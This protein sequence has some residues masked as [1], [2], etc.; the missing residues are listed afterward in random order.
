MQGKTLFNNVVMSKAEAVALVANLVIDELMER[1]T[2]H[3]KVRNYF[4]IAVL[5][6]GNGGIRSLLPEIL[7]D[8]FASIEY[9]AKFQPE[10][11]R[12]F[13]D[14]RRND[15][16]MISVPFSYHPW[17]TPRAGG[18]TPMYE[19]LLNVRELV[20]EWCSQPENRDSFPPIVFNI[21]DGEC[22]DA[23]P[24]ELITIARHITDISTNDGNILLINVHLAS[25]YS[26]DKR[27]V[28]ACDNDFHTNNR[29]CQTL[30]EMSSL[31]P[32]CMEGSISQ[33]INPGT[34]GPYRGLAINASVCDM[35]MVLNMGSESLS[36]M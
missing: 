17:I 32:K 13:F 23:S 25:E 10:A 9:L 19:A 31:L 16:A 26:D 1:A 7:G 20:S 14:V 8:G 3:H 34:C 18:R 24:G 11:R 29:Y 22:N 2:R 36:I 6:Y 21:T 12:I 28:F 33:Y 35:L 30:F 15:G 4:D 5:G 27:L